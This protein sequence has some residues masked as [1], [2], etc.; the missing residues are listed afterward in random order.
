[1]LERADGIPLAL[2]GTGCEGIAR[3]LDGGKHVQEV[4]RNRV[5]GNDSGIGIAGC[6]GRRETA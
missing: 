2:S 5:V 4:D 6:T 1:M 3:K